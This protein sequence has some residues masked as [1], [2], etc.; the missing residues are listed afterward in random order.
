[1]VG[2]AYYILGENH[3]V[4][5]TEFILIITSKNSCKQMIKTKQE[6]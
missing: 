6:D 4:E 2:W 5:L 1:M 3:F